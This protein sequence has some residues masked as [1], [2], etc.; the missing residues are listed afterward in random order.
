MATE[1]MAQD[2]CNPYER[3]SHSSQFVVVSLWFLLPLAF[4]FVSMVSDGARPYT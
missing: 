4:V 2:F 1:T 3:A